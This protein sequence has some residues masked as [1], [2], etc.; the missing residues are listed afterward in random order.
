M[1]SLLRLEPESTIGRHAGEAE[2]IIE[3][4]MKQQ[5]TVGTDGR[6]AEHELHRPVEV[7][8]KRASF[9]FTRRMRRQ[10]LTPS[11]LA[12]CYYMGITG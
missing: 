3:F 1:T 12:P 8:P 2:G 4:A 10:R 5:T 9:R 6:A 11:L 7:E